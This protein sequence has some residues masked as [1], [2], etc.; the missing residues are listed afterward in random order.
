[1]S[2]WNSSAAEPRDLRLEFK[3]KFWQTKNQLKIEVKDAKISQNAVKNAF[4]N[5]ERRRRKK[6]FSVSD[7]VK[8][9]LEGIEKISKVK[10]SLKKTCSF[11]SL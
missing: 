8:K 5:P 1:M 9:F 6:M 7:S 4:K 10:N 3:I 11:S 2:E